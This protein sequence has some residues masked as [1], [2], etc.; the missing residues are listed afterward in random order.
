[1]NT[2]ELKQRFAALPPDT[3]NVPLRHTWERHRWEIRRHVARTNDA[4]SFLKWATIHATMFVGDVYYV[5]SELDIILTWDHRDLWKEVIAETVF[6]A[7]PR[8]DYHSSTSGNMVHQAY[9]IGVWELT[10][11]LRVRNLSNIVEFGGGYGAMAEIA[12]RLGAKGK[13]TLIDFPEFSL[14]QKYYLSNVMLDDDLKVEYA[15]LDNN[16]SDGS[17]LIACY[18]LGEVPI[19]VREKVLSANY[20]S[21]LI[22]YPDGYNSVDNNKYFRNFAEKNDHIEWT[23]IDKPFMPGHHYLMGKSK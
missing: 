18:S 20:N 11:G 8:L 2:I 13:Y 12:S 23:F 22:A 19:H 17:L 16:G 15:D 7:A 3:P 5:H 10:T 9:H 21:Y 6:G 14:L 4:S 1:M